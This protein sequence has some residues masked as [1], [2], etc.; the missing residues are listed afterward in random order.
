MNDIVR[1]N[2]YN[3]KSFNNVIVNKKKTLVICD[4]DDTILRYE[5]NINYFYDVIHKWCPEFSNDECVSYANM[6]Y[7]T[8]TKKSKPYHTDYNGFISL[9]YKLIDKDSKL[10][11]LTARNNEA[12]DITIKEFTDIRVNYNYFEVYYTNNEMSKG[13]YCKKYID[14]T[15]INELIMIDDREENLLYM[16]KYFPLCKCYKYKSNY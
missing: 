12:I 10:I 7:S 9:M 15:N 8:Y 4:I 5:K 16:K 3:I 11:F 14:L 2:Y 1:S 13:G 6:L